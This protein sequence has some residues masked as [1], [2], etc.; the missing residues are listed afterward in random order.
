MVV[1]ANLRAGAARTILSVAVLIASLTALCVPSAGAQTA[2]ALGIESFARPRRLIYLF[3]VEPGSMSTFDAFLLYNSILTTV[4][5]SNDAVV[6]VESP[7]LEVPRTQEGREELARRVDADSWLNVYVAGGLVDLTV[8]GELY[9]MVLQRVVSEQT[10]RPGFP[11]TQRTLT[12][13]FWQPFSDA[14]GA[15][16]EP[17]VDAGDV[18]IVGRP[19]TALSGLPGGPYRIGS[20]G[21]LELVLPTPATYAVS[22]VAPGFVPVTRALYLSDEAVVLDLVQLPVY[23]FA[24]DLHASS[25][26]FPGAQVRYHLV[27]GRWFVRGGV[28]TQLLGVNFVPNQPLVSIGRSKLS[29]LSFDGGTVIG[30]VDQFLR[31]VVAAG[32]FVRFRHDPLGLESDSS[33]GGLHLSAGIEIAPWT[34][35]PVLRSLRLFADYR[36]TLALTDDPT[37]FL[38]RSF[39]WNAFP[40]GSVPG[41]FAVAGGV[42][43]LRD[44]YAGIRILF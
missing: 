34:T 15:G 23:R 7:D 31:Y 28:T 3:E 16:F 26:Q 39:P 12:R 6:V 41:L 19:G 35:E 20:G 30:G 42:L 32:G 33:Y 22:A 37:G 18:V 36:P 9:D 17:I 11:V 2:D 1:S 14:I 21:R 13:G 40:G 25:F 24:I 38:E 44:L 27:P 5:G 8:R 29:V 10:V 43:D 4:A